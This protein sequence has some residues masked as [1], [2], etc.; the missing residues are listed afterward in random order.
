M[1]YFRIISR[2]PDVCARLLQRQVSFCICPLTKNPVA[3][4]TAAFG[5][6]RLA[7]AEP[8]CCA[9]S[10]HRRRGRTAHFRIIYRP[11]FSK[12]RTRKRVTTT[13][14]TFRPVSSVRNRGYGSPRFLYVRIESRGVLS[15][16][17]SSSIVIDCRA[18]SLFRPV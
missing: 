8:Q 9:L 18:F 3:E 5:A 13:G 2:Y 6:T 17:A 7:F 4:F 11:D 1:L 15:P 10:S 16:P 14:D 12:K